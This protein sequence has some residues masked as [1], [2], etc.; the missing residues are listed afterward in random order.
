MNESA[1]ARDVAYLEER[2]AA[3]WSRIADLEGTRKA[4]RGLALVIGLLAGGGFGVLVAFAVAIV[5]VIT[6]IPPTIVP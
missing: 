5:F 1:L 6:H 2:V 4:S 3:L